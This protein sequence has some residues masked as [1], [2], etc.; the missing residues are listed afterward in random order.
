MSR[1]VTKPDARRSPRFRRGS[2]SRDCRFQPVPGVSNL[3]GKIG[4]VV[5]PP[6]HGSRMLL[7][8]VAP[9]QPSVAQATRLHEPPRRPIRLVLVTSY[10][11]GRPDRWDGAFVPLQ[12]AETKPV[13]DWT[14]LARPDSSVGSSSETLRQEDLVFGKQLG[15]GVDR[16]RR[17]HVEPAEPPST[18]RRA[19]ADEEL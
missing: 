6:A 10:R 14:L 7:R 8:S 1:P 16:C 2:G 17:V 11:D 15:E 3:S 4:P 5:L 18:L 13:A 19:V 9:C 12:S